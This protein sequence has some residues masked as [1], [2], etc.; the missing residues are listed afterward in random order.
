[1]HLCCSVDSNC[2]L[3][4]KCSTGPS[5]HVNTHTQF[6]KAVPDWALGL[7]PILN[8]LLPLPHSLPLFVTHTTLH[9]DTYAPLTAGYNRGSTVFIAVMSCSYWRCIHRYI[10]YM[11]VLHSA[12]MAAS[13]KF[14][15]NQSNSCWDI[16]TWNTSDLQ[17]QAASAISTRSASSFVGHCWISVCIK[18]LECWPHKYS[19]R[20]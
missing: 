5:L 11:A 15:S 8:P 14:H 19:N 16:T 6:D 2:I 20:R 12:A 10:L 4:E 3:D 18:H 7:A 13:T 17:S 9:W 1:M